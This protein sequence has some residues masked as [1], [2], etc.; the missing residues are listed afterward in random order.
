[1]LFALFEGPV[2]VCAPSDLALDVFRGELGDRYGLAPAATPTW[3]A[4][5]AL[6]VRAASAMLPSSCPYAPTVTLNEHGRPVLERPIPRAPRPLQALAAP[7][8]AQP[9]PPAQAPPTGQLALRL[10]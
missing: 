6:A 2:V 3:H 4:T 10:G 8:P 7:A 5:E 1:V 9:R